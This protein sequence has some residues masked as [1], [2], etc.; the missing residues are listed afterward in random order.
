[1]PLLGIDSFYPGASR[2]NERKDATCALFSSAQLGAL[3]PHGTNAAIPLPEKQE[4]DF[5]WSSW[6]STR[7]LEFIPNKSL[8]LCF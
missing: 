1:M 2:H 8:V 4:L 6:V 3:L 5:K 7:C